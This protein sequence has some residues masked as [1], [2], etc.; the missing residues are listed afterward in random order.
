M[1]V[2]PILTY[3]CP[4]NPH[5]PGSARWSK[6][7]RLHGCGALFAG[8]RDHEGIVDCPHCGLW[9]NPDAETDD[10]MGPPAGAVAALVGFLH[11]VQIRAEVGSCTCGHDPRDAYRFSAKDEWAHVDDDTYA[12]MRHVH[13]ASMSRDCDGW[14]ER[15]STLTIGSVIPAALRPE[16][17]RRS[18]TDDLVA[19][20]DLWTY[21]ARNMPPLAH[22]D[23]QKTTIEITSNVVRWSRNTD[24]GGESGEAYVCDDPGCAH[25]DATQRDHTAERAGY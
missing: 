11:G 21:V 8:E 1:T 6:P 5:P 7:F 9:F 13:V 2:G 3:R 18:P 4:P 23:D 20:Y 15:S 17:R 22:G 24:E 25:D 12:E 19:F 10:D 16:W 14:Y